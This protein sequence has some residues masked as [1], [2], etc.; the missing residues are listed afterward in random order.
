MSV[1]QESSAGI[2][3]IF[4][5]AAGLG[6][7]YWTLWGLETFLIFPNFLKAEVLSCLAIREVT[8]VCHVYK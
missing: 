3:K 8:R 2:G 7:R 6:A 5:L 1:F 4:I